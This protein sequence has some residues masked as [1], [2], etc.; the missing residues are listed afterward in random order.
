[1]EWKHL[2]NSHRP[3]QSTISDDPREEFE[4]DF[5]RSVFS[6]PLK[7]LQ[8]KAQVFPLEPHDAVRTRLTH[9]LEVSSVARGLAGCVSDQLKGRIEPHM[10]R[11]IE[12]IAATCGLIHDLG[13]PPFGHAGERAIRGWFKARYGDDFKALRDLLGNN[14]QLVQDFARFES[15]AQT[16]RLVSKLQLLSD[17]N[18]LNLTFGTL[19][20][21]CK[22]VVPSHQAGSGGHARSKPGY[23]ASENSLIQKV[24]AET[25]TGEARNPIT[26]LVEAAD[27]IVYSV[28][29]IEDG[30]KKG[31]LRWLEVEQILKG[32]LGVDIEDILKRKEKILKAGQTS[33]PGD[34]PD[35]AH[36]AGF[37]IAA[38]G[39][40]VKSVADTFANRYQQIMNGEYFDELVKEGSQKRL[41]E[42]FQDLGR[43][44]IYNT[45]QT[46]KLELMGRRIIL[47]L[48][49]LFWEGAQSLP[50]DG[51]VS[52][53][54]FPDKLGA[55]ISDNYRRVFNSSLSKTDDIPPSYHR[56]QLVTDYVCGMTDSFA[57]RLHAELT[58]A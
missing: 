10:K 46:L 18:G 31:I 35:D 47:D 6:T 58:N 34:L 23:F 9:S 11:Q 20:A 27:D 7:R 56:F 25:G 43:T 44:R 1:M 4:R 13:N 38:I 15:N 14:E 3:R 8:D 42:C 39:V 19:S 21:A 26:F 55:L 33:V 41:I 51:T 24:R 49:D 54:E 12:S 5:A 22:Y 17:L 53:T 29:D 30:I 28:A 16:L 45:P 48:M 36:A 37:R 57:R 2:L 50:V 40:L 32:R 52:T